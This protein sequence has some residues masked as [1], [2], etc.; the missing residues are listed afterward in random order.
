MRD[1]DT[2]QKATALGFT[3]CGDRYNISIEGSGETLVTRN[4]DEE[5]YRGRDLIDNILAGDYYTISVGETLA[6][7][8]DTGVKEEIA[9][10]VLAAHGYDDKGRKVASAEHAAAASDALDMGR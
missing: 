2:G 1:T 7:R 9:V 6:T 4:G 8:L 10:C 5:V 3:D